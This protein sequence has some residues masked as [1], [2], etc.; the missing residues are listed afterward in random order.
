MEAISGE[1]TVAADTAFVL[2]FVPNEAPFDATVPVEF[3]LAGIYPSPFNSQATIRFGMDRPEAA[4]LRV[5]DL[6][7][8]EVALL[9]RGWL[10]AGYTRVL[11]DASLMP[12]GLYV[13]RLE[14]AGRVETAKIAL[15]R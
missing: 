6:Q 9:L 10:K 13:I 15:V 5:Y 14:S 7:G 1:D 2:N 4:T 8:R 12:S 3:G 11:W